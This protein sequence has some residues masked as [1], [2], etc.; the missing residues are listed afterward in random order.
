[1]IC[2]IW[3]SK[4]IS[5]I[6]YLRQSCS[7]GMDRVAGKSRRSR[8]GRKP[9]RGGI[10]RRAFDGMPG[11]P[12]EAKTHLDRGSEAPAAGAA[13]I[14]PRNETFP[15]FLAK[16]NTHEPSV[17]DGLP[18]PATVSKQLETSEQEFYRCHDRWNHHRKEKRSS[19]NQIPEA[20]RAPSVSC[21]SSTTGLHEYFSPGSAR[22]LPGGLRV[23]SSQGAAH[24]LFSQY[25][26]LSSLQGSDTCR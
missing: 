3:P 24:L 20:P 18:G 15:G 22:A 21:C 19:A 2:L 13:I 6:Y 11:A 14:A 9:C 25:R 16:D 12:A 8:A 23:T 10:R 1:M 17:P 7:E 26:L 5:R 4:T